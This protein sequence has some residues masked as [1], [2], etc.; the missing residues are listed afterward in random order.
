ML[1]G[2][3]G[4]H[5]DANRIEK[6]LSVFNQ[7]ANCRSIKE[8]VRMLLDEMKNLVSF[9]KCTIFLF[10]NEMREQLDHLTEQDGM[11]VFKSFVDSGAQISGI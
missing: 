7:L 1:T 3:F 11:F 8:I 9:A 2:D 6:L 4:N 10:P 5:L